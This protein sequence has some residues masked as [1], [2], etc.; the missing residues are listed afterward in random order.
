MLVLVTADPVKIV[1]PNSHQSFSQVV[2]AT[3]AG[4]KQIAHGCCKYERGKCLSHTVLS[5]GR[6]GQVIPRKYPIPC[7]VLEHEDAYSLQLLVEQ[8][9]SR[10]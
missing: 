6:R 8:E 1:S 10:P 3:A 4:P 2:P 5:Q 9:L 7:S